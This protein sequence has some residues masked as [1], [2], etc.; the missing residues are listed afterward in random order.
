V[1]EDDR[2]TGLEP[3]QR[4]FA[5]AAWFY[6]EYR[7]RPSEAFVRRLAGH[8]GWSRADRILDLGAGPAHLSLRLAPFV[9][10]VVVMDPEP[11]M[12][13]EGRRRA[14]AGGIDNLSFVVGGSDDLARL[15]PGLGRFAAV[16]ISQAF[17]WMADQDA[18]LRA[19]DG[20]IDDRGAVALVGHVK[21]P[22]YNLVWLDQP[23][24][25]VVAA[26]RERH[27]ADAPAPPHPAGRHDPF[28][29]IL[30]RSA[31][32]RTELLIY[33][34]EAAIHPSIDAAIGFQY[35]LGNL[36]ARLGERRAAFEA[37]VR[38]ALADADTSPLTVRLVDSALLGY[39]ALR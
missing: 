35:S 24:W 38:T 13:E 29:D 14:A 27:L 16:T 5:E 17:H 23:P 7:Y 1:T 22:D 25:N 15:A 9:G 36:L 28:P 4:P 32:S 12:I 10:E 6:A 3:G 39:R 11:A 37:D 26:I 30:A 21:E 20:L 18:V 34:Y 19:L 8:L 33:D 31:F 2:W